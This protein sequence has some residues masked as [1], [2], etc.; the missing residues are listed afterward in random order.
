MENQT[1]TALIDCGQFIYFQHIRS[2]ND[3]LP[4]S[5]HST[6]VSSY[7]DV[8]FWDMFLAM[9][10]ENDFAV[11]LIWAFLWWTFHFSLLVIYMNCE[12]PMPN[13]AEKINFN[14]I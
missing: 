4:I 10:S 2:K 1:T 5:F 14:I 8:L 11:F 9:M 12:N 6:R 3:W 13:K 7:I